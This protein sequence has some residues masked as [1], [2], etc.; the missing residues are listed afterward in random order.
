M[1]RD[2]YARSIFTLP[3]RIE[4]ASADTWTIPFA[5]IVA[6]VEQSKQATP[7]PACIFQIAHCGS[8]LLSRALD[9]PGTSLVI[10]EPFTLRQFAAV[11]TSTDPAVRKDRSRALATLWYLL[12][13]QYQGS[14]AVL[15]KNNVPVNFSLQEIM[16]LSPQ[17]RGVLLY[18]TIEDYLAAALKSSQRRLWAQHVVRELAPRIR[19]L[20]GFASLQLET[21]TAAQSIAVLWLAQIQCYQAA[22]QQNSALNTLWCEDLYQH[23]AAALQACA[24]ELNLD[25]SEADISRIVASELFTR[26]AKLPEQQYSEQQRRQELQS[27]HDKYKAEIEQVLAWCERF[28]FDTEPGLG[29]RSIV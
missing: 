28:G 29:D 13:R 18:S 12:G 2:C 3:D 19:A 27:L 23:P 22:L 10:R 5:E 21:L 9:Q 16:Q 14:E 15:L 1:S 25:F 20:D 4:T 17:V 26:H 6:L 7:A 11:P 24:G 8:T